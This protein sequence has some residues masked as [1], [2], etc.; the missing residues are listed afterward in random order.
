MNR[1]VVKMLVLILGAIAITGINL[2]VIKGN[3]LSLFLGMVWGMIVVLI[4]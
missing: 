3:T 4:Q 2:N 1:E